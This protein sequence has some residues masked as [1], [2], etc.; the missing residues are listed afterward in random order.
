MKA[1]AGIVFAVLFITAGWGQNRG[2]FTN[3]QPFVQGSFGNVVFPGG[4]SA[5]HGV[6]RTFGNSVFPSGA[7][8]PRL[9]VP[10]AVTD[11]TF[12]SRPGGAGSGFGRR[13]GRGG[14]SRRGTGGIYPYAVPVYVGGFY[15]NPY[16]GDESVPPPQAQQPNVVVVYPPMQQPAPYNAPGD[17]LAP[18]PQPNASQSTSAEPAPPEPQQYLIAFKDHTIYSALAFWV[19]GDTL[20][21]FTSGNTHNQVSLSLIDKPLTERLN[22]ES[23]TDL[24]LP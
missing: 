10:G 7:G 14:G 9:V 16:V 13:D 4:T 23:G 24:H 2:G 6:T 20:H 21:Y 18:G 12:L 1:L 11:P 5:L 3:P 8:F 22:R 17:N 19:D 15:D